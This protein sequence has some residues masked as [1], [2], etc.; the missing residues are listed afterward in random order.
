VDAG[1]DEVATFY[2]EELEKAGYEVSVTTHSSNEGSLS[3]VTGKQDGGAIV[4]S[5]SPKGAE[6]Q[7]AVQYNRTP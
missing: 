4:A 5:V 3:V 2:R 6:T 7:A 1:A